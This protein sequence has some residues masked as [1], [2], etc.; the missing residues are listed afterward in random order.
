MLRTYV[1]PP[2]GIGRG[3][4][5]KKRRKM[6]LDPLSTGQSEQSLRA[7]SCPSP[8]L[9]QLLNTFGYR[10]LSQHTYKALCGLLY[11]FLAWWIQSLLSSLLCSRL[12]ERLK[13][14]TALTDSF[15]QMPSPQPLQLCLSLASSK[16]SWAGLA[17]YFLPQHSPSSLD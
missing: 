4:Q 11:L 8:A 6:A 10:S 5:A 15:T 17:P 7:V 16:F 2:K 3:C 14:P 13:P 1:N 9:P 12:M